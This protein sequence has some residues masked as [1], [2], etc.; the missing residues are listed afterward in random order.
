MVTKAFMATK[1]PDPLLCL[2]VSTTLREK[3]VPVTPA[4]S[5]LQQLIDDVGGLPEPLPGSP[6]GEHEDG[7]GADR[8]GFEEVNLLEGLT[9]GAYI[10]LLL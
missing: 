3:P 8:T 7:D 5:V 10:H 6:G 2:T 9:I 4:R 1:V